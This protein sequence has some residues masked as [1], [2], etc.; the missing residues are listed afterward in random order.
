MSIRDPQFLPGGAKYN[1]LPGMLALSA[2]H[3]LWLSGETDSS[4]ELVR[5]AYAAAGAPHQ[6]RIAAPTDPIAAAL[7]WLMQ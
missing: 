3:P 6:L 2:P 5:D 7:D 1:D 4:A